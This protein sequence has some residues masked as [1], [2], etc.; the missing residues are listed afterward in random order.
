MRSQSRTRGGAWACT[1]RGVARPSNRSLVHFA[2]HMRKVPTRS[3]A[4][5]WA[6]VRGRALGP[7]VRR[8]HPLHPFIVDFYVASYRLVIELDGSVHDSLRAFDVARDVA[9]ATIRAAL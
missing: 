9:L 3:E 5:L 1:Q 8:Q 4:V 2:R 7:R 6:H